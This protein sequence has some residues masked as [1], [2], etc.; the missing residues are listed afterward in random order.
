MVTYDRRG[1][2]RSRVDDGDRQVDISAHGDDL[3]LLIAALDGAPVSVFGTSFG[4]LIALDLERFH[5]WSTS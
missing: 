2:S 5:S 4:A 3:H 1:Y